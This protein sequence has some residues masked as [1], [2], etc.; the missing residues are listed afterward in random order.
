VRGRLALAAVATVSLVTGACSPGDFDNFLDAFDTV[1]LSESSDAGE[2]AAGEIAV[3][4]LSVRE[5]EDN[6]QRGV[7]EHDQAAIQQAARLRPDDPKYPLYEAALLT[8]SS[9]TADAYASNQSLITGFGLVAEQNPQMEQPEV[10]RITQEI[11]LEALRD[12]IVSLPEFEGRDRMIM[13][14]CGG[15]TTVYPNDNTEKFPQQVTLYLTL[16]ADFSLCS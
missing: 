9:T 13:A 1:D 14:Y 6:L 3:E 2:R 11:Y 4:V 7:A 10:I 8:Q 12:F 16:S 5:A 15:I